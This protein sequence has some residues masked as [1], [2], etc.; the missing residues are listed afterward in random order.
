[1]SRQSQHPQEGSDVTIVGW[2]YG[3][4]KALE[5]NEE[6]LKAGIRAEIID[7]RT[8]VPLDV[9]TICKSVSKT[10]KLVVAAESRKRGSFGND[11]IAAAVEHSYSDLRGKRPICYVGGKDYPLPFGFGEK[12]IM[13]SKNDLIAGVKSVLE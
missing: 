5:A 2:Q 10:G 13:P 12:Y 4:L 11:I 6:L 8:I 7:I 1:L 9:D 3:I